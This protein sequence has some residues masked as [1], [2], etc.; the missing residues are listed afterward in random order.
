MVIRI[1]DI[2][3]VCCWTAVTQRNCDLAQVWPEHRRSEAIVLI[4]ELRPLF[5]VRAGR[6]GQACN[7]F[8]RRG[9]GAS[10]DKTNSHF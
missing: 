7:V 6:R 5:Q 2:D 4:G 8:L 3:Q 10:Q 9:P 1:P